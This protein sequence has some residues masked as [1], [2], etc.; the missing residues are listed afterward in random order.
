MKPLVRWI[1]L[2]LSLLL[3][4]SA[5]DW[6]LEHLFARPYL[7]GTPPSA[8]TWAKDGHTLVFLWNESG[9]RFRELYAYHP[10]SRKLVRLT[11]LADTVD[12]F[13]LTEE[14]KDERLKQYQ[15][16]AAGLAAFDVQNDGSR[17]AFAFRG[18][19]YLVDTNGQK[20]PFRLT[21]T[22]AGEGSPQFSPD[23]KKLAFL[24][25][26][27]LH[28][29]DLT[30]GQLVQVSDLEA[31]AGSLGNYHWSPDGKMFVATVRKGA[32]RS[33]ALPNY[34]GRFVAARSFP[35]TVAGDEPGDTSFYLMPSDG[36]KA[37][38]LGAGPLGTKNYTGDIEWSPDSKRLLTRATTPSNKKTQVLVIDAQTG[39]ARV[40]AEENDTRWVASPILKWA[41]DSQAILYTSEESG[42]A[43]L[44]RVGVAPGSKP[45]QLTKGNFEVH[46]DTF[47]EEPQWIGNHIYFASTEPGPDQRWF[48]RMNADG[49]S[50]EIISGKPG[51]NIGL[52]S[53]DEKYTV[54]MRA[55]LDRPLD[56][57]DREQKVTTSARPEFARYAW[58]KTVFY[59]FPSR[60]D[61][62]TVHAKMLLPP[63][64]DPNDKSKQWPAVFFVH[65]AGY[66]TSVLQQWGSYNDIRYA[67]NCYLAHKG[68]V[69]FD[70]DYR[71]STGYGRN[72]RSD[73]YLFMGGKDLDDV[74]GGI[75]YAKSL[76]NIDMNR[77]G[78]WGVS[79]GGFMT[80]MAMFQQPGVFKAGAAWAGVYDW[81]NYN[82]GYTNQR[83]NT[84]LTNPEAYRRSS[85]IYFSGNLKDHLLL[86][87]GMVDDNVMFQDA[88]QLTEKLVQEHKDFAHF[89]YPEESHAFVR[90][91]TWIDAFRRTTEWFDRYLLQ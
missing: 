5:Q 90:D 8:L 16:P 36:G 48:Y 29:Q 72:W 40:A 86:I 1:T 74:I 69:I 30:T 25:D 51:L 9:D 35:R 6:S 15:L 26:R 2:S 21:R 49:S 55:D 81:E 24:R 58:P 61:Q 70:I 46:R 76:G 20:P 13:N 33:L 50:K 47:S 88:V 60:G 42:Y 84:P 38:L 75:A 3:P 65:G 41:P 80:A 39:K 54:Y 4:L 82:A 19:L 64:Y 17:V 18:D 68:Y 66:A 57:Y 71:G 78:V 27:Q 45:Q 7:W 56:L 22:K 28:V 83:L 44:Y 87:H 11:H 43:Q 62:A 67:Y 12:E 89:Y 31:G 77:I 85:P 52:V 23:G 34:S 53:P 79:Y 63:G 91:D 73:I 14:E 37:R 59:Q 32:N 10:E